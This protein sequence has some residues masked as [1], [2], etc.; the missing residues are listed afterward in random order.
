MMRLLLLT[1]VNKM[2]ITLNMLIVL[3][4][5]MRLCLL[6]SQDTLRVQTQDDRQLNRNDGGLM[7]VDEWPIH[8]QYQH[9]T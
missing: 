2:M 5:I 4:M 1:V 8:C 3:L 7:I 9:E 6:M